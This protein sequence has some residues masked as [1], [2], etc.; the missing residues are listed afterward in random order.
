MS[1]AEAISYSPV[2]LTSGVVAMAVENSGAVANTAAVVSV[3]AP[4]SVVFAAT[5]PK[6]QGKEEILKTLISMSEIIG[7]PA[8]LDAIDPDAFADLVKEQVRGLDRLGVPGMETMIEL[9]DEPSDTQTEESFQGTTAGDA[10]DNLAKMAMVMTGMQSALAEVQLSQMKEASVMS[11]KTLGMIE[12]QRVLANNNVDDQLAAQAKQKRIHRWMMVGT[13][14]AMTLM[15][16]SG[17]P[18]LALMMGAMLVMQK[19]GAM[20]KMTS[21]IDNPVYKKLIE[22]A[23]LVALTVVTAGVGAALGGGTAL[24]EEVAVQAGKEASK[25]AGAEVIMEMGTEAFTGLS[26]A[27]MKNVQDAAV[28]AVKNVAI[29]GASQAILS[30]G[31]ITDLSGVLADLMT[32]SERAKEKVMMGIEVVLT[33][34]LSVAMIY[35]AYKFGTTSSS[36]FTDGKILMGASLG[37]QFATNGLNIYSSAEMFDIAK[38]QRENAGYQAALEQAQ[39]LNK[40]NL[41]AMQ[42][43][44]DVGRQMMKS[45]QTTMLEV[46]RNLSTPTQ[47]AAQAVARA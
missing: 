4:K 14:I 17:Q 19:T 28:S 3:G 35:G 1:A 42:T 10:K 7:N 45:L 34:L 16:A 39:F 8:A 22:A 21:G 32:D 27:A 25:K 23:V 9:L 5:A 37:A 15:V 30:S 13:V 18:E 26:D 46:F 43:N 24:L 29:M 41:D 33:V 40:F 31:A 44:Q 47:A 2:A 11:D 38:L 20:E 12:S 6:L 36:T